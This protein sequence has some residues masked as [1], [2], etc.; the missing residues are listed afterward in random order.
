MLHSLTWKG[1]E[2]FYGCAVVNSLEKALQSRIRKKIG[3]V[4]ARLGA[5]VAEKAVVRFGGRTRKPKKGLGTQPHQ[6]GT[7]VMD[8]PHGLATKNPLTRTHFDPLTRRFSHVVVFRDQI[9]T[10]PIPSRR[11]RHTLRAPITR[12]L[13]PRKRGVRDSIFLCR[14]SLD[15]HQRWWSTAVAPCDSGSKRTNIS[16]SFQAD[17]SGTGGVCLSGARC[18]CMR[19]RYSAAHASIFHTRY[20]PRRHLPQRAPHRRRAR[21]VR[22]LQRAAVPAPRRNRRGTTRRR[23]GHLARG[24]VAPL[25]RCPARGDGLTV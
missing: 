23:A 24:R 3:A 25:A 5:V 2:T 12:T 8:A 21:G 9:H 1:I 13:R 10:R 18:R 15:S 16:T 17:A 4:V 22:R 14:S 11:A 7:K 20:D 19:A 6:T